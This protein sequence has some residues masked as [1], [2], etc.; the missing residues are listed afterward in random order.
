MDKNKGDWG[1]WILPGMGA[2]VVLLFL[3]QCGRERASMTE[4]RARAE[5]Q[6]AAEE[7]IARAE[8][9]SPDEVA[10]ED[11]YLRRSP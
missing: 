4:I 9:R 3:S 2:V 8:G 7:R 6:V 10:D 1:L 11:P 5:R